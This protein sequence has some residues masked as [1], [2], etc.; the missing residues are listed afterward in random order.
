MRDALHRYAGDSEEPLRTT[1]VHNL[2]PCTCG[3]TLGAHHEDTGICV[4]CGCRHFQRKEWL[5][6]YEAGR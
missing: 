4:G 6:S 1:A 2:V 5:F 3:H